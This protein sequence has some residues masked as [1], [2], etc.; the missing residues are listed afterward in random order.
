MRQV[1]TLL[2]NCLLCVLYLFLIT[3]SPKHSNKMQGP[4]R[5]S[6]KNPRYF[7]DHSGKAI[8]LT[9]S[10]TW[11]NLVDMSPNQRLE[12][13]DFE[14]YLKWMKKYNHN[15]MRL[16]AWELMN[17]DTQG[18][19]EK[20]AKTHHVAPHPWKRTGPG[21]ALDGELKFDLN[22]WNQDYFD[23]IEQRVRLA[24]DSGI[25]VSIMLFEGWGLQ[26]SPNAFENHPFHPDNNINGVNGDA[27]GNGSGV[28]I[29][30]LGNDTITSIQKEYVRH[31]ID[32]VNKFDN[33]LFEI[34][35]ENHPPST[36]WQYHMIGFIKNYEKTLP[37]Q[38]TVGMTFQY[39]GGSNQTL[40]DSPADWISPNP[41]GGYRDDP[42]PANG[43]KVIITD[44]DHL[45]GIG[46]N[47]QWVWKSFLRG[48]NP[49]FMDPYK[50]NVLR[51]S[52]DP[53]W[54]EPIRKS[55][56]YTRMFAQR[57]DLISMSPQP[58][59]ASSAYCLA[60]K[61]EVLVYLPEGQDVRLDLTD[62][63]GVFDVEW[64]NP[65]TGKFK[66]AESVTGNAR[67]SLR[68]PFEIH[69]AVLYLS[70]K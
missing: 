32:T 50:G 70:L 57:L 64:F 67:V 66:N 54:V 13:F 26:F 30:T 55:M 19:R 42:P 47:Q 60:G 4:L 23:R 52:F 48:L 40:F 37:K 46:G 68:C 58:D 39:K 12:E 56:G 31:V 1:S 53:S 17:W 38:H 14:S 21:E 3:C 69:D 33:V 63:S 20:D 15:F 49:I 6:D 35:N 10:H 28:E 43:S 11:N 62:Y 41:E 2:T 25:S 22:A 18:N 9:G 8:Y 16:W 29:H 27:D 51:E 36:D 61:K 44:T 59:M 7:T 24:A 34:S 45:W 5:V 65:N